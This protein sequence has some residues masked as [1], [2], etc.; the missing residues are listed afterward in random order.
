MSYDES[1][2]RRGSVSAQA[3]G[4]SPFFDLRESYLSLTGT[5]P[6]L[7]DLHLCA[8]LAA[9]A[10]SAAV[11]PASAADVDPTSSSN[12]E[13]SSSSPARPVH[14]LRLVPLLESSNSLPFDPVVRDVSES[15]DP[16]APGAPDSN[17]HALRIGRFTDK[18]A[19]LDGTPRGGALTSNKVAFKS[20]VVSR[21]HAEIWVL[22]GGRVRP[23]PF[24]RPSFRYS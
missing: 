5:D 23:P 15:H 24:P 21:T 20:K 9:A 11:A 14:R 18:Q 1:D 13:A 2:E 8:P 6:L 10:P 7:D 17:A 19:G 22:E 4:A 16:T 3:A 12:A